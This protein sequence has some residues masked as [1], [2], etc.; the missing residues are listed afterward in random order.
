MFLE[1]LY[2]VFSSLLLAGVVSSGNFP[3]PLDEDEERLYLERMKAGDADARNTIIEHN[4][5]L[6][7]HIV[8][9]YSQSADIDDLISIGT[10]GLVKGVDS[11]DNSKNTRLATYVAR[12][13]EN[14]VLMHLR[15]EKK[16]NA[17]ISLS[18]P[19]GYDQEGNE[20]SLMDIL[21]GDDEDV[22]DK[23]DKKEKIKKLLEKIKDIKDKREKEILYLRYGLFGK[24]PLTQKE[25]AKKLGISRSYVSRIEKKAVTRLRES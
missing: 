11:F 24:E 21:T 5:R 15:H 14:E 3:E 18:E 25:V 7:A 12:C 23:V 20:I 1:I 22:C 13:I 4:L 19:I 9:K 2:H 6:V 16:F 10:I 8:K 17:Q